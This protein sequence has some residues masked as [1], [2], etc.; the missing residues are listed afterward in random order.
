MSSFDDHLYTQPTTESNRVVDQEILELIQLSFN[1]IHSDI[2]VLNDK[3]KKEHAEAFKKYLN[4]VIYYAELY[5]ETCPYQD[6]PK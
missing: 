1:I 4:G 5:K 2:V 6:I 3:F